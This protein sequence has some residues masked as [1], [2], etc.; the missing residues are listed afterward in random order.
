MIKGFA[1]FHHQSRERRPQG[2]YRVN[3]AARV[4]SMAVTG[5][6]SGLEL[7]ETANEKVY[8]IAV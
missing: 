5:A 2:Q 4:V 6:A 7:P 8:C 1:S 3:L